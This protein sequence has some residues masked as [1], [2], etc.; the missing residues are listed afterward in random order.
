M[1][2]D[3]VADE[4]YGLPPGEFVAARTEAA[5]RARAA[6]DRALAGRIGALGR[7]ST[8]AWACNALVREQPDEIAG[9]VELGDLLR[10]AQQTLAGDELRALGTQRSRLLAALTRQAR[11]V[12]ARLGHPLSGP[13]ADQVEETLRAA[14]ADPEAGEALLAGRLTGPLSY[15]GTGLGGRPDLRVVPPAGPRPAAPV[16]AGRRA[17]EEAARRAAEERRRATEERRLRE[18]AAA[19][20]EAAAAAAAAGQAEEAARDAH[21]RAERA[22]LRQAG[23]EARAGELAAELER[24]REEAAAAGTDAERATRRATAAD[25]V[26]RRAAGER[27]RAAARLAELEGAPPTG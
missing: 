12:A 25:R 23:L 22:A 9:L 10:E 7:P 15:R 1:D 6:G 26:A 4:L 21:D 24:V 13:V 16:P 17:E 27:D 19:R 5:R 2:L 18:L 3:E 11:G 8:A 14:L 20:E